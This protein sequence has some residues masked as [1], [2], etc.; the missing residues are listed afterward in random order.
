[1]NYN[2][3]YPLINEVSKFV[4]RKVTLVVVVVE[5]SIP[6]K[7]KGTDYVST[8]KIVDDS[9]QC[10]EL[11]V[12]VFTKKI[13][14]LPHVRSHGDLI[15][16]SYVVIRKRDEGMSAV[17]Y[18]DSSSFALFDGNVGNDFCCYQATPGFSLKEVEKPLITRLRRW[19]NGVQLSLG[20]VDNL[21]SLKDIS[22]GKPFDL[23]CKVL[24][25]YYDVT[26]KVWM[27]LL[28]DGTDAPPLSLYG[29]LKDEENNP[30]PLHVEPSLM[31]QDFYR[32]FPSFGTILRVTVD[33]T[34]ENFVQ[35]FSYV[36]K[37]VRICYI[38]CE[39]SAGLWHGFLKPSSSV[40]LLSDKI[41]EEYE[42]KYYE[43]IE[44]RNGRLPQWVDLSSHFLTEIDGKRVWFSTL[45]DVLRYAE[46][47]VKFFCV[48]RVVAIH[49]FEAQDICSPDGSTEHSV[50]LT[51]E[52]SIARIHAFLGGEEW[53]R[54]FEACPVDERITKVKLLLG[55]PEEQSLVDYQDFSRNPPWIK[56][57]LRSKDGLFYVCS[58]RLVM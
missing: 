28:W 9:Q 12:N 35:H 13:D 25:V 20:E 22:V 51:I 16:L 14:D 1:M 4:N 11:L 29:N 15:L 26:R 36:D 5:S 10:P 52:D 40:R 39:A 44:R 2:A 7:S 41:I 23:I 18:K 54:F 53:V 50:R 42:G 24:R 38:S 46:V 49:P 47:D 48:V 33:E 6:R 17:F 32:K 8:L 56:C 37:W 3:G 31:D 27:L 34:H 55:V 19:R 45:M 21:L 57:C 43:R 30:L 58:T